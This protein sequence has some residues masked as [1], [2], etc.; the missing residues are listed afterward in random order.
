MDDMRVRISTLS[1]AII[2]LLILVIPNSHNVVFAAA[3]SQIAYGANLAQ[4][5]P[6]IDDF[7]FAFDPSIP[8]QYSVN[9][10]REAAFVDPVHSANFTRLFN[11]YEGYGYNW[12]LRLDILAV[13]DLYGTNWTLPQWDTYVTTVV[14]DFPNVHVWEVGNEVLSGQTQYNSGYLASGSLSLAYFNILKDAYGIVKQHNPSDTVIAL[15]GQDI[16]V[17]GNLALYNSGSFQDASYQLAAQVWADGG[18]NYC[19]AISLHI[20]GDNTGG[21]WLPNE[22]VTY[23]GVTSKNTLQQIWNGYINE[24]E[25]LTGKPIWFTETGEPIDSPPNDSI[26]PI[27]GN[28]LEKQ[29]AFLTQTFTFL[30]SFSFTRA[31]FWFKLVGLSEY[32]TSNGV[33][34]FT[35]DDG[36]FNQDGTARPV[37]VAFQS[38][39]QPTPIS[40][41]TP[42]APPSTSPSP[43]SNTPT[44]TPS[45][46]TYASSTSSPTPTST[47]PEFQ[48]LLLSIA[49]VVSVT[50]LLFF[51]LT[52]KVKSGCH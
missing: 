42:T 10:L 27:I 20:Y 15:G 16:F 48:T 14:N 26:P 23:N 44:T 12:E 2:L 51:K 24:Y 32:Y 31:I 28:S 30:S 50:L 40:S 11:Q 35:L 39:S 9:W 37:T 43:T 29:A 49:L 13:T 22:T 46:P 21:A 6:P 8:P 17:P 45:L 1:F 34:L 7:A 5:R 19:D 38:F 18:A 33:F 47:I 41:P 52:R 25:Q 3:P 4:M 36:L